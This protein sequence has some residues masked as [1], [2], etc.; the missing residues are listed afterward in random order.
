MNSLPH[1]P[2]DDE[3]VASYNLDTT[4]VVG[5]AETGGNGQGG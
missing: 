3:T 2:M 4:Q 5:T 1:T